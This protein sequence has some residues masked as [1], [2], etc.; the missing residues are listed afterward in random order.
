MKRYLGV[1][2][3]SGLFFSVSFPM[4]SPHVREKE[5]SLASHR[6]SGKES[7]IE[8]VR[9]LSQPVPAEKDGGCQELGFTKTIGILL[10][11]Q[12]QVP[13]EGPCETA[14]KELADII[15]VVAAAKAGAPQ[16]PRGN[17]S[18]MSPRAERVAFSL[19]GL[20]KQE[21]GQ[22]CDAYHKQVALWVLLQTQ[23]LLVAKALE[24][25][26][27][28]SCKPAEAAVAKAIEDLK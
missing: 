9:R 8:R 15:A 3:L 13:T 22:E 28:R 4:V 17:N 6:G 24:F 10:A 14:N 11:I 2:F 21:A 18:P 20:P 7:P 27:S 5:I 25:G 23:S 16:T 26:A 19:D 12:A 1:I